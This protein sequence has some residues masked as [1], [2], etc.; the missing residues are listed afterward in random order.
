MYVHHTLKEDIYY[1]IINYSKKKT[2]MLHFKMKNL[3]FYF[4]HPRKGIPTRQY[5]VINSRDSIFGSL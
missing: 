3:F 4:W 5:M 1:Y 2:I